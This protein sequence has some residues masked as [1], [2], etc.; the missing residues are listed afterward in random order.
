MPGIVAVSWVRRSGLIKAQGTLPGFAN[1][2]STMDPALTDAAMARGDGY[3]PSSLS[4]G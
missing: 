4:P 3:M 1:G 2:A